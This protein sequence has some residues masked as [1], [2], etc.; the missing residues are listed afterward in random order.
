VGLI[1]G[2][3]AAA[4]YNW[5]RFAAWLT[6]YGEGEPIELMQGVSVWPT[7]LLRSLSIIL[8][9]YL[10]WRAWQKLNKELV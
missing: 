9:I 1:V 4:C 7:I 6:Q 3:A 8:S 2:T 5:E 10:L